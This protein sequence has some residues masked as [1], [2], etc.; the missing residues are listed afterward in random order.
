ML[1]ETTPRTSSTWVPHQTWAAA[2]GK[3]AHEGVHDGVHDEK[4][5]HEEKV[6]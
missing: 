6:V 5:Q 4:L 2:E 3:L 1:T